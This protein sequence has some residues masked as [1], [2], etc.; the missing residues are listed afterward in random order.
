M[1]TMRTIGVDERPIAPVSLV[2]GR[3]G[4]LDKYFYFFM[5]L[6]IAATVLYG[7]S[8]TVDENLIHAAPVRPFVLYVH[9]VIFTGWL[10]FYIL[11]SVLVRTRNVQVHRKLGWFGVA[12]G[13]AIPIVG[14]GTAVV[15]GRFNILHQRFPGRDA[16]LIVPLF[17]V[18]AFAMCFALAIFWRK[19]SEFHRRLIFVASCALTAA[20]FGRFPH[21][22][23]SENMF[24]GGVDVLILLGVVRDLIVT[25]RIHAVYLY[26]LPAFILGQIFVVYTYTHSSAWWMKIAHSM[27]G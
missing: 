13:V 3:G 14:A 27:L 20:A 15:M 5:S 1:A 17:D 7:F 11:Q 21:S 24:Y 23:V 6:L 9:A 26:A 2:A 18:T 16:F 22:L 12:L 19:K 8:H 10:A 25:K 4:L